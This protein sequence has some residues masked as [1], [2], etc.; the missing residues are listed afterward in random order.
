MINDFTGRNVVAIAFAG[1]WRERRGG[2]RRVFR[3]GAKAVISD[4][5]AEIGDFH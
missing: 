2:I 4:V 1:R 5:T 3:I